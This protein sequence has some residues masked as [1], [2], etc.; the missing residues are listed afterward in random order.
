MMNDLIYWCYVYVICIYRI[1]WPLYQG[2]NTTA[3]GS[4]KRSVVLHDCRTV[5]GFISKAQDLRSANNTPQLSERGNM[6]FYLRP[7]VG[8]S[9]GPKSQRSKLA[10]SNPLAIFLF[11]SCQLNKLESVQWNW[12]PNSWLHC[13]LLPV[14]LHFAVDPPH[15]AWTVIH[16]SLEDIHTKKAN[17]PSS[18]FPFIPFH[19]PLC[20]CL[21]VTVCLCH[22]S[23]IYDEL[24]NIATSRR[25]LYKAPLSADNASFHCSEKDRYCILLSFLKEW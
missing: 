17:F 3:G 22:L 5:N 9:N 25:C 23:M 15:R 8:D 11:P 12:S 19:F 1:K 10:K 6:V 13:A 14:R 7:Y 24:H 16:I 20:L 2:S 21:I 4:R 18:S